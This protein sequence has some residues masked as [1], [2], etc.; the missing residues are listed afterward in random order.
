M[1]LQLAV[2]VFAQKVQKFVVWSKSFFFWIR[3]RG[4]NRHP[5]ISQDKLYHSHSAAAQFNIILQEAQLKS[6]KT[7]L[8][9]YGSI[10]GRN[11][12]VNIY[13]VKCF[14]LNSSSL[15]VSRSNLW[16]AKQRKS[17]VPPSKWLCECSKTSRSSLFHQ[18][19]KTSNKTG[20][21]KSTLMIQWKT[22]AV[23]SLG[24]HIGT[25]TTAD[26]SEG[27]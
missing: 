26:G 14:R 17:C 2:N 12:Q 6:H 10:L 21:H 11:I 20:A 19:N 25:K 23:H 16:L 7:G 5:E 18:C 27:A 3:I 9:V 1:L 24:M 8:M 15:S 13:L 4:E 22:P